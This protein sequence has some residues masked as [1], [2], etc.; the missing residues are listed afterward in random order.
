[1]WHGYLEQPSSSRLRN[2]LTRNDVPIHQLHSS[3]HA[4]VADLQRLAARLGG[5][6]VPIHTTAPER[7]ADLFE[8]VECR[9]DGEWWDV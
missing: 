3:G 2:W 7:F 9:R 6:V 1:M 4:C 5:R 8:H